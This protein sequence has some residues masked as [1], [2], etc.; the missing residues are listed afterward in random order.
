MTEVKLIQVNAQKFRQAQQK[1][2]E[3]V[4]RFPPL[5]QNYTYFYH[6]L[7]C[8]PTSTYDPWLTID[9]A[10]KL[11]VILSPN[12]N[13]FIRVWALKKVDPLMPEIDDE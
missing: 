13:T 1:F 5:L 6:F 11:D 4:S 2:G 10:N 3:I 9:G 12:A 8:T 7:G